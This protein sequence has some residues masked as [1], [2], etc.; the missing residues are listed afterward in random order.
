MNH[1]ASF[2]GVKYITFQI[3][4][5]GYEMLGVRRKQGLIGFSAY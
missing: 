3:Q 1:S 5:P 2:F 4:A